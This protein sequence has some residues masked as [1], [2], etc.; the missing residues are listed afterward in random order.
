MPGRVVLATAAFVA[1]YGGMLRTYF[2]LRQSGPPTIRRQLPRIGCRH[3]PA[4]A[5][6]AA[7]LDARGRAGAAIDGYLR[8]LARHPPGGRCRAV[9]ALHAATAALSLGCPGLAA[10]LA[11]VALGAADGGPSLDAELRVHAH[12]LRARAWSMTG[13]H[14]RAGSD[15][16]AAEAIDVRRRRVRNAVHLAAAEVRARRGELTTGY[17]ARGEANRLADHLQEETR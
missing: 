3:L 5:D 1:V 14:A 9:V 11:A 16:D 17:A 13:A 7:E 12:A 6:Q 4:L 10:G 8:L 15:L 2:K